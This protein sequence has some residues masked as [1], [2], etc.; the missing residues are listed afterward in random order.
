MPTFSLAWIS[1][2]FRLA[3]TWMCELTWTQQQK[4]VL[5][6]VSDADSLIPDPDTAFLGWIPI[7]IRIQSFDDKKIL[8]N[9]QLK[10]CNIFLIKICN[11]HMY[12]TYP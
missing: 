1:R 4:W 5:S 6:G 2:S 8:K 7:R 10:K 12:S 9:L 3:N 11:L